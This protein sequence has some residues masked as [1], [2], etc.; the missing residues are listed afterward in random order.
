MKSSY[1]MI[2]MV[3]GLS[4]QVEVTDLNLKGKVRDLFLNICNLLSRVDKV[5]GKD[6]SYV[7]DATNL[8]MYVENPFFDGDIRL[9]KREY[10]SLFAFREDICKS[11]FSYLA[12]NNLIDIQQ[13]HY[14]KENK[15][16]EPVV[17][18]IE[19]TS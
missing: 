1:K 9:G 2:M 4:G 19:K 18:R 17:Y 14:L 5:F 15:R 6:L 12:E 16:F 10:K 7:A 3:D 13:Y 11:F 8:R